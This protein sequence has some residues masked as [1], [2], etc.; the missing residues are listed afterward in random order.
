LEQLLISLIEIGMLALVLPCEKAA[1]PHIHPAGSTTLLVSP[2]L[3]RESL[4]RGI[5]FGQRGIINQVAEV[6]KVLL[7]SGAFFERGRAPLDNEFLW[8]EC[9]RYRISD[10]L[11]YLSA[12]PYAKHT[13]VC[14]Q[15]QSS[16]VR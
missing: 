8:T 12:L 3:E 9:W 14:K 10:D 2:S 11:S 4:A 13:M 1:L 6:D 16:I 7:S 5:N 15:A